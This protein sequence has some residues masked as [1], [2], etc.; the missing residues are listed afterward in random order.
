MDSNSIFLVYSD[1]MPKSS[2][3]YLA[4]LLTLAVAGGVAFWAWYGLKSP[5]VREP[6][7]SIVTTPSGWKS[8]DAGHFTLYAPKYAVLRKLEEPG[9]TVGQLIGLGTYLR[10]EFGAPSNTLAESGVDFSQ[11]ETMIDGRPA[12]LRKATLDPAAQQARF[13]SFAQP[14]YIGVFIPRAL[15]QTAPDG[16][17]KCNALQIEGVGSNAD[18]RDTVEQILKSIRF[19]GPRPE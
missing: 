17:E 3:N 18:Q 1:L 6:A 15:C 4:I 5:P 16:K 13:G 14:S 2:P 8:F 10:Y 11:S 7:I 12:V 9:H 19:A